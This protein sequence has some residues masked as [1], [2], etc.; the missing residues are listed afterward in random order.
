MNM[1]FFSYYSSFL[2]LVSAA[3][4]CS[5]LY[6]AEQH[7]TSCIQLGNVAFL[8]S[9]TQTRHA[10]ASGI[11]NGFVLWN[12]KFHAKTD[13]P[14]GK[15]FFARSALVGLVCCVRVQLRLRVVVRNR[16]L[17][18][19]HLLSRPSADLPPRVQTVLSSR[20]SRLICRMTG[21]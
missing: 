20:F 5:R 3:S 15:M 12:E 14:N 19:F 6:R 16:R 18:I 2:P 17:S 1:L 9:T 13:R 10:C 11:N 7:F 21:K 4:Y 8:H